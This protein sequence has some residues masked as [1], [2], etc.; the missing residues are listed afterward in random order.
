M[1]MLLLT[2]R[3]GRGLG[4][5][6]WRWLAASGD[7]PASSPK[8]KP[9]ATASRAARNPSDL[10]ALS[11]L[12]S[13]SSLRKTPM[14][15]SEAPSPA[16]VR[17]LRV[18]RGVLSAGPSRKGRRGE[19]GIA[20]MQRRATFGNA[21]HL[22]AVAQPEDVGA[23]GPALQALLAD[24]EPV[25]ML[26]VPDGQSERLSSAADYIAESARRW[27]LPMPSDS[28]DAAPLPREEDPS[29]GAMHSYTMARGGVRVELPAVTNTLPPRPPSSDD[30]G[31]AVT[32]APP[33]SFVTSSVAAGSVPPGEIKV[34]YVAPSSTSHRQVTPVEVPKVVGESDGQIGASASRDGTRQGSS[35]AGTKAMPPFERRT[36]LPQGASFT[37]TSA[38]HNPESLLGQVENVPPKPLSHGSPLPPLRGPTSVRIKLPPLGGLPMPAAMPTPTDLIFTSTVPSLPPINFRR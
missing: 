32:P 38:P 33:L 10:I 29:A 21:T 36:D 2:Q 15:L 1:P 8:P 17:R 11:A 5:A 19:R 25:R 24:A 23:D 37:S 18:M 14:P 9:K 7:S 30:G 31:D 6:R 4:E 16:D 3:L 27:G 28:T 13:L 34:F 20:L 22:D 26:Y 12:G 35:D